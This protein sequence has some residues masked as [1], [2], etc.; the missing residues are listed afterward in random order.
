MRDSTETCLTSR[1]PCPMPSTAT[2]CLQKEQQEITNLI[3][4][5]ESTRRYQKFTMRVAFS[6]GKISMAKEGNAFKDP[7][8]M[9]KP[10]ILAQSSKSKHP[11]GLLE[12]WVCSWSKVL[13]A[14]WV[15]PVN[16]L[17][18]ANG[19]FSAPWTLRGLF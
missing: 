15:P 4:I 14:H 1:I 12:Y 10:Q 6:G 17:A 9:A 8:K 19:C 13:S 16:C 11:T 5:L 7:M 3:S 2:I 18:R